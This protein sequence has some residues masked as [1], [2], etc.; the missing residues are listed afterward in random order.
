MKKIILAN[1]IALA[2]LG[3]S[4]CALGPDY[5]R[6]SVATELPTSFKEQWSTAQ[7][8]DQ[9]IPAAWWTLF[10]DSNLTALIEQ[11]DTANLTLAQAQ[12]SYR[13]ASALLDNAQ[14]AYFPTVNANA[15][16]SKQQVTSQ[17]I[18]TSNSVGI[19]AAWEVDLWGGIR[20]AVEQQ[21]DA[22]M[23]SYANVQAVRLSLQ[24]QL[25]QSYFQ[26]RVLDAQQEL[27]NRTVQEYQRSL[28]LTQNQYTSGIVANDSVLLAQTQLKSTQA[29]A[30]DVGILR[31]QL[32]HAIAILVGKAPAS[33]SIAVIPSGSASYV[34]AIPEIP[35]GLPSQLLERRAD[36]ASAE[37]SVAAANAQVG[38]TKAAYFP[39]LT[40]GATGGYQNSAIANLISLPNR[41][42]SVGP[43]LA[44]TL[45]DGGAKRALNAQA[46][47]AY[48]GS[49]AAYRLAVLSGFQ[50]VE[51]N[52][53]A[54]RILKDE[55]L[56]QNTAT[57]SARKALAVTMN[58]Y[59]AG[60]VTYLN[61]VT[62]QTTALSNERADLTITNAQLT[63][64]VSLIKALGG[65]WNGLT[66]DK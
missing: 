39:N 2:V 9:R 42:W 25:A 50:N 26:L 4:G 63:A 62:A 28:T 13:Q 11:I 23:S 47:A 21:Q 27:L 18:T 32:E 46:I 59:K 56:V 34:P 12:A 48:D 30:L 52:L 24:A 35:L 45:F 8:Q 1:S 40:L 5:V 44:G 58:R 20:R 43:T 15:A 53:V 16:H 37:R 31:A 41:V 49:V 33:F 36:I 19:T 66:Q 51:D 64:V 38:V 17:G 14:A 55:A 65:G 6:P 29:Q 22:A 61:V 7:P 54:L 60:T 3:L 57:E 10:N